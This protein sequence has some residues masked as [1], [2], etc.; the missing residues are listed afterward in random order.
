MRTPNFVIPTY[1]QLPDGYILVLW[2]N[3]DWSDDELKISYSQGKWSIKQM[4]LSMVRK[5]Q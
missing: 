1:I 5:H 3:A 2:E 4:L